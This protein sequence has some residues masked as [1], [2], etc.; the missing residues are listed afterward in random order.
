MSVATLF[1][2]R[3]FTGDGVERVARG[4]LTANGLLL[5]FIA[6]Q[7]Y[8]HWLIWVAAL[9]AITFPGATWSLAVLFRR[10]QTKT[11]PV[12]EAALMPVLRTARLGSSSG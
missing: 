2:A 4:F 5:P 12:E 6:L 7:M 8:V 10:A 9:W 11:E 1:M 3:V